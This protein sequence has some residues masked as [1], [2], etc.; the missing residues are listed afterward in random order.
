MYDY[1]VDS[2]RIRQTNGLLNNTAYFESDLPINPYFVLF[3]VL[4]NNVVK[5]E[6]VLVMR[7][8]DLTSPYIISFPEKAC[9]NQY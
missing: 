7:L 1:F 2:S 3:Q 5:E 4:S 8:K 6:G 9:S